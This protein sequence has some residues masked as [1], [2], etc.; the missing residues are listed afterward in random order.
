MSSLYYA[1]TFCS[2]YHATNP[3]FV[4]GAF[5]EQTSCVLASSL[6]RTSANSTS[7]APFFTLTPSFSAPL[8]GMDTNND[9][10]STQSQGRYSS[11]YNLGDSSL[12]IHCSPIRNHRLTIMC[13]DPSSC[14]KTNHRYCHQQ[15]DNLRL[16][17][18]MRS[19][20]AERKR[21]RQTYTHYQTLELEKEFHFDRYL[22]RRRR[23]EIAHALHLTERQ[24][25]IWFQNRRMK[26]KKE[27][28][29][30]SCRSPI[31]G[32]PGEEEEEQAGRE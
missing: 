3:I 28:K 12:D 27:K 21:G 25:K 30:M 17:P 26:L 11:T 13:A 31:A 24:I 8:P 10:L 6:Q 23:V 16:Y 19:T 1:N 22:T 29:A 18:W 7:T 14:S 2:Q 9:S 15:K 20:G 32:H 4:N 5:P